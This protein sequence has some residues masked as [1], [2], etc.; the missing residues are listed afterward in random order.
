MGDMEKECGDLLGV[1]VQETALAFGVPDGDGGRIIG[2]S[3]IGWVRGWAKGRDKYCVMWETGHH[4][5][6]KLY[7]ARR[8][9]PANQGTA[10]TALP[11]FV[12]LLTA[13]L[14]PAQESQI[15]YFACPGGP[16]ALQML[17]KAC[18]EQPR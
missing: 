14:P 7:Q 4:E 2:G 1:K 13:V 3:I 9:I 8:P 17:Q 15:A 6:L 12:R 18:R 11:S 16:S 10:V 5:K